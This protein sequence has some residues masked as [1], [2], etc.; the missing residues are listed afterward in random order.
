MSRLLQQSQ[1]FLTLLL[2]NKDKRQQYALVQTI[3]V[4]QLNALTEIFYNLLNNVPLDKKEE[5]MVK[6]KRRIMQKLSLI[7]KSFNSRRKVLVSNKSTFLKILLHF[8]DKLLEV[9]HS[10]PLTA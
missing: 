2:N 5:Q 8:K 7:S 10:Q 1:S 9:L 3:T 6:K 4:D